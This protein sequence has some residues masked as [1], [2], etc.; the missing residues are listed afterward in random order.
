MRLHRIVGIVALTG[1]GIVAAAPATA[2][3]AAAG[4]TVELTLLATTDTHGH[5]FN[6]D[7]F[8]N[9]EYTKDADI[10]GLTRVGTVVDEVRAAKGP[11]SVL[12]FDNGDAIQGTP[13][14]YYYGM[15]D[16]AASVLDN[17]IEH[18]MAQAFNAIGYDAQVVGNHEFNYGLDMLS[19]YEGDLNAPLLGANVIDVATG[20]PY[21]KPYG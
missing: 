7:Y 12:V 15:G 19:A 9:A 10:L 4:D 6:W 3:P 14:T 16:G 5:V 11:E 13:L 17:T 21:Q 2:A 18:P 8:A 20:A 1:L